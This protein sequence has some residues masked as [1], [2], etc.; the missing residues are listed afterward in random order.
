MRTLNSFGLFHLM[1]NKQRNWL[2]SVFDAAKHSMIRFVEMIA[3]FGVLDAPH[4]TVPATLQWLWELYETFGRDQSPLENAQTIY[5]TCCYDKQD[6]QTGL[7]KF[8]DVRTECYRRIATMT[9]RQTLDAHV[10]E[11]DTAVPSQFNMCDNSLSFHVFMEVLNKQPAS[12]QFFVDTLNNRRAQYA[13]Y[14]LSV[15]G[16]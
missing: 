6:R 13:Q 1:T 2:F 9:V 4:Q 3:M 14:L 7:N 5:L 16:S 12:L 8:N 10:S 15:S 11:R